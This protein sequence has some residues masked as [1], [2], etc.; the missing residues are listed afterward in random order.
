MSPFDVQSSA[1]DVS[2]LD[3]AALRE[4]IADATEEQFR[5]ALHRNDLDA[6]LADGFDE[7]FD[8][9]GAA[10]LPYLRGDVLVCPGSIIEHSATGH[11]CTFVSVESEWVWTSEHLLNDEV[12]RFPNGNRTNQRSV[13]L[14]AA[15]E[16]LEFDVVCSKASMGNHRYKWAKSFVIRR[17]EMVLVTTRQ[18]ST[19]SH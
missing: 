1:F 15:T 11:E 14:V 8:R 7:G 6:L 3:D 18:A 12:R 10:V 16:G 4:L 9:N 13:S 19:P 2:G 5:R 17:G